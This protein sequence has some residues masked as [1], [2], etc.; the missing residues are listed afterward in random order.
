MSY[1]LVLSKRHGDSVLSQY[2]RLRD[3]RRMCD[4]V[5]ESCGVKFPAHR[6]LLACAS[7]YFWAL[8]KEHTRE[9][10]AQGPLSLPAL[11]PTGLERVLDFI[12]TSWLCLSPST[13]EETLEAAC[14]LQ[15]TRAVELCSRYIT[16][17][18]TLETCCYFAN[19]ACRYGLSE[20]LRVVDAYIARHMWELM[21]QEEGQRAGLM[22]LNVGSLQKA[23]GAEDVPGVRE[24]DLLRLALDWLDQNKLSPL[25]S[26]LLLSHVR[27]GLV[28]PQDLRQ[29]L[30]ARPALRTPFI[31]SLVQKAL[32]YHTQGPLQPLLQSDST[33]IRATASQVLLVGGGPEADRPQRLLQSFNPVSRKF[34]TLAAQLPS[35]L[36][37]HCVC[38]IGGFLFVL[39]GEEVEADGE[40]EKTAVMTA[41]ER[42]W[43]YDPRFQRW[44][45]A[46]PMIQR[47]AQF[48]CCVVDG[49]IYAIGGRAKPGEP[50]LSTVERYNLR[51]GCWRKG[52]TLPHAIH[53]HACA[54][55]GNTAYIS[56]GIHGEEVDSSR[57]VLRL[58]MFAGD[59][60]EKCAS[61]S[62]ARFGHQMV[63]VGERIYSF[64]GMYEQFCDIE[65]YDPS[66][67]QWTRI[68]PLLN[69][70]FCYGLAA[71]A[72][73]R[74][75]LFGG[76]KW[77]DGQEVVM[78]NVMEYDTE[79]DAWRELCR[80]P[81]PLCGTKCVQLPLLHTDET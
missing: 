12:Y 47:R 13:L 64:L 60:W 35:R 43:R 74:V 28:T 61:M 81:G 24:C 20:A 22:E 53:G 25:Q 71:T 21:G 67:D 78:A 5:L 72:D 10:G 2:Q 1:F 36:Q 4:I 58:D 11:T 3:D 63:A 27:F 29:L 73:G 59:A 30:V 48:S 50:A 41:S 57:D 8:L 31:H 77:H 18:L 51:A 14:Y 33:Q 45:E 65:R 19:V 16:D 49:V 40:S 66:R 68:R 44:D 56:G 23:L 9:S 70:R 52:V 76:R 62:I 54:T 75:L 55:I 38:A 46:E 39:G 34:R 42:V 80:M 6:T 79:S 69:D 17:N 26:N 7:D 37:H 15:V 32:D